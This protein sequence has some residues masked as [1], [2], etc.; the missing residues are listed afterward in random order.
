MTVSLRRDV[1]L[2]RYVPDFIQL[3]APRW[4]RESIVQAMSIEKPAVPP[5]SSRRR[6]QA[7]TR[8]ARKD[9]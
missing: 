2:R 5:R 8:S 3:V 7:L 6:P 4:N 9:S 1:F